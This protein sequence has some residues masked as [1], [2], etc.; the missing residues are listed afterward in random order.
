M[1]VWPLVVYKSIF[2]PIN[3]SGNAR[4]DVSDLVLSSRRYACAGK[5]EARRKEV[6]T[7]VGSVLHGI[8]TAIFSP[9]SVCYL[10]NH[11]AYHHSYSLLFSLSSFSSTL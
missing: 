9:H 1:H 6:F 7:R 5:L 8:I 2:L 3:G 10:N 11:P 4:H